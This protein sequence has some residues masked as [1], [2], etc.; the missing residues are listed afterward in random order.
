VQPNRCPCPVAINRQCHSKRAQ[1][2]TWGQ[3]VAHLAHLRGWEDP[4]HAESPVVRDLRT[5]IAL[6]IFLLPPVI[7]WRISSN[8]K[9]DRPRAAPGPQ[10]LFYRAVQRKSLVCK[11]RHSIV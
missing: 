4:H 2:H 11:H 6:T 7:R 8:T 1:L 5:A 9:K 10:H 3:Q